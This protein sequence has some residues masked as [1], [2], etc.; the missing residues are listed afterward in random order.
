VTAV[1]YPIQ[2]R[3]ERVTCRPVSLLDTQHLGQLQAMCSF[4]AFGVLSGLFMRIQVFCYARPNRQAP[5]SQRHSFSHPENKSDEEICLPIDT[6]SYP[7]RIKFSRLWNISVVCWNM[8]AVL[9]VTDCLLYIWLS[10]KD[11]TNVL[12]PSGRSAPGSEL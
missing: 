8:E 1:L 2:H 12:S 9:S 5:L 3:D 10:G 4:V 11:K 6:V 7:R